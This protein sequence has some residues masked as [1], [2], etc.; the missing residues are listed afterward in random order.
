MSLLLDLGIYV[1]GS[2]QR[3]RKLELMWPAPP[4]AVCEL[5]VLLWYYNKAYF[6]TLVTN[7]WGMMSVFGKIQAQCFRELE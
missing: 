6:R 7:I 2:G 1:D 3:S 5:K 4:L